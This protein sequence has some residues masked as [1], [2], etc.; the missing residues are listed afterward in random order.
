MENI[1]EVNSPDEA[2]NGID[3]IDTKAEAIINVKEFPLNVNTPSTEGEINLVDYRPG[4]W[5]YNSQNTGDGL[6][7]FSEVYYP[8]GFQVTIDGQPVE[9]LRAN[10]VL[11]ALEIPAGNHEIV[12][13]FKPSIYSTGTTIMWIFSVLVVLLFLGS[14]YWSLRPKKLAQ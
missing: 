5:K 1:V 9:M 8:K 3:N 2:F 6:A 10:Y 13:E 12:F 14:V 11:R 7:V 4:Y